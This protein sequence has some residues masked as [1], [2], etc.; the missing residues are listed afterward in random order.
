[1]IGCSNG[2]EGFANYYYNGENYIVDGGSMFK[3]L[4]E[5]ANYICGN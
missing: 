1:M 5:A 4:D 2:I 3:T